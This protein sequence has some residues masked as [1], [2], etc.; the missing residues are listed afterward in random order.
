MIK[1]ASRAAFLQL[2]SQCLQMKECVQS[3]REFCHCCPEVAE[4][5]VER[6]VAGLYFVCCCSFID[7]CLELCV[8]R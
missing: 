7:K 3:V 2:L 8:Q 6:G 5:V 1:Y 4:G